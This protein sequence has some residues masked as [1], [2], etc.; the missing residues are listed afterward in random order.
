MSPCWH[1]LREAEPVWIGVRG[2]DAAP[3][4]SAPSAPEAAPVSRPRGSYVLDRALAESVAARPAIDPLKPAPLIAS[5]ML[6][7]YVVKPALVE[8][9]APQFEAQ[10]RQNTGSFRDAT[11]DVVVTP[12]P[13]GTPLRVSEDGKMAI[14]DTD[15][16]ARQA[17]VFYAT[18]GVMSSSNRKLRAKDSEYELY[19]AQT[20]A[21]SVDNQAATKTVKLDKIMA[22]R[23]VTGWSPPTNTNP[24]GRKGTKLKKKHR[25]ADDAGLGLTVA[26]VCGTVAN[27][28]LRRDV[29][30][31][32]PVL[33]VAL[34]MT[35]TGSPEYKAARAFV[36]LA[37]SLVQAQTNI[38]N[39]TTGP[40]VGQ[41]TR[42]YM[43]L[44]FNHPVQA[45]G[46]AQQ[47]GVNV[48]A[49]PQVGQAFGSLTLGTEDA[50]GT[51]DY[52]V[53]NQANAQLRQT[54][55]D[56]PLTHSKKTRDIWGSHYGAV[57]ATSAG[58]KVTFENYA[59][60]HEDSG[61]LGGGADP[62][63]YFQMYGPASNPAQTWHSQWTT[64]ANPVINP[65][66]LVYG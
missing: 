54:T 56:T 26:N 41:I 30:T 19:K 34:G 47:L 22:R 66:T 13:P 35:S 14:E 65:I 64:A 46:I 2:S 62:V 29:A 52:A 40:A 49:D 63:Y 3:P 5:A 10:E 38:N 51:L 42:A 33:N 8:K 31:V 61:G 28:I 39:A 24:K 37:V 12:G 16:G 36:D 55:T 25:T 45:A 44:M 17:K 43:N 48:F 9:P 32:V 53:A 27:N 18:S 50:H 1:G 11:D 21:I 20:E 6:Q 7:R 15:L 4:A 23:R 59:R 57:V 60:S 58:N